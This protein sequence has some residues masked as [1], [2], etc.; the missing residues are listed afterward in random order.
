MRASVTHRDAEQRKT[1][2]ECGDPAPP[3]APQ[4]RPAEKSKL[5]TQPSRVGA[6]APLRPGNQQTSTSISF[7][8]LFREIHPERLAGY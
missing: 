7:K 5:N 4:P 1:H 3:F 2:M 8:L 6:S